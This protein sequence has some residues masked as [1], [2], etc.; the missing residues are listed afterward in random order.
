MSDL[1]QARIEIVQ[2]DITK[3]HVDAIVNAANKSLLGGG[4]VDGAI[5][6]AAGPGLLEETK[7]LGGAMTGEAV[8]TKGYDL[9]AKYVIHAVGPVYKDG[10]SGEADFLASCYRSALDL[11][12]EYKIT[13]IAF[14]SI[15]TG[16]YGYPKQEAAE[17][18]FYTVVNTLNDGLYDGIQSVAFVA[19]DDE[20]YNIYRQLYDSNF[21]EHGLEKN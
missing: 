1:E 13:S 8:I 10:K 11:A 3:M 6:A 7:K 20:T 17:I 15:S 5:H 4:G 12:I 21:E 18:A 14:P 2:G 19:Y 16:V 9:N